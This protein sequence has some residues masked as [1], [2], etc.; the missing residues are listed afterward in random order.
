MFQARTLAEVESARRGI[1][2]VSHL[3]DSIVKIGPFGLGVDGVLAWVPIVGTVYSAVAGVVLVGLGWRARVSFSSL[4][5][6]ITLLTTRTAV[7]AAGETLFLPTELLV[8]FF[9]AHKWAAD[10]LI[11]SIDN[12]LYVEGRRHPSNPE[13]DDVRARV[14]S[15]EERRRVVFLG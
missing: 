7:T 8:D 3:S 9:R 5:S 13:Y 12:T 10:A 6:A 4:M 15:G 2:R 1:D 11:K 14:R